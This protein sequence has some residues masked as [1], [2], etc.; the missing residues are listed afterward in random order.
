MSQT[1]VM[2]KGLEEAKDFARVMYI[3]HAVV[4][5]FSL[6]SLSLIPLIINYIK[7]PYTLGTFVYSHH[8]WMIR[9]FW[10]SLLWTIVAWLLA[11]TL[12]GIP[13]ALVIW[14]VIWLW[15]LYRIIRGFIDLN[16][17]SAM[18]V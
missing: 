1:L 11:V 5:V 8:T 6:G 18:P 17:N 7:R 14:G 2:D 9:T 4:F 12:I 16:N 15:Y 10:F 13:I 3:A